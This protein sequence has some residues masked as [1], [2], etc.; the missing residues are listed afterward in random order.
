M[1]LSFFLLANPPE[2]DSNKSKLTGS[3]I[4]GSRKQDAGA[5]IV[6]EAIYIC[7]AGGGCDEHCKNKQESRAIELGSHRGDQ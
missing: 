1:S 6:E 7:L 5:G 2:A 3:G 4:W